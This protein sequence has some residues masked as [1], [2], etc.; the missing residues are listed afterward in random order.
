MKD[1]T[2]ILME[3][4]FWLNFK[5]DDDSLDFI[6]YEISTYEP[7]TVVEGEEDYL[8]RVDIDKTTNEVTVYIAFTEDYDVG[9]DVTALFDT[10]WLVSEIKKNEQTKTIENHGEAYKEYIRNTVETI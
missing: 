1:A 9:E 5:I 2:K 8:F 4:G 7:I 6:G 3:D 10:D